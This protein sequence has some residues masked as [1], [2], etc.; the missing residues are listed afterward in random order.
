MG[1]LPR[2]LR[3]AGEGLGLE[4][5]TLWQ[6]FLWAF[7]I[8]LGL[9]IAG[10]ILTTYFDVPLFQDAL[11]YEE[12]GNDIAQDWFAGRNSEWLSWLFAREGSLWILPFTIACL[13]WL[14]G[15]VRV[16][17][18]LIAGLCLITAWAPVIVYRIAKQLGLSS[19]GAL[20]AG[21]LIAFSPAFAF[22]SAAPY[23]EG[24][25]IVLLS[26]GFL[27]ILKL[28]T[29][30]RWTSLLVVCGCLIGLF[31]LRPYIAVIM[32]AVLWLGVIIGRGKTSGIPVVI[33][34]LRQTFVATLLGG[35]LVW[36]GLTRTAG[37]NLPGSVED[38]LTK[39]SISR[40]DLAQ[41]GVSGFRPD[42]TFAHIPDAIE[43]LPTG[44]AYFLFSPTPWQVGRLRQNTTIPETLLW[45]CLYPMAFA[46]IRRGLKRN[47]QGSIT[48][49]AGAA[50][51]SLLYALFAGNIGVV[52]RMRIQVWLILAI[53]IGWGWE[54]QQERSRQRALSNLAHRRLWHRESPAP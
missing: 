42:T 4:L 35:L 27:H 28:Q 29:G 47:P 38:G 20:L 17:P 32:S 40:R 9:G 30:I 18:L 15:G 23:K 21:R 14:C 22:W 26:L 50:S 52:Y 1:T 13:Y 44:L 7:A 12:L 8:R 6:L 51:M 3:P 19:K 10:W 43:F 53:F 33:V 37:A 36:T 39:I 11:F 25:I 45:V 31:G 49:L 2:R 24:L 16:M 46:G 54:A 41:S 34:T 5:G 48:L